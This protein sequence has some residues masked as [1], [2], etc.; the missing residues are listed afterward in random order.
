MLMDNLCSKDFTKQS[1]ARGR[2]I[3]GDLQIAAE[4]QNKIH[5]RTFE[6]SV[7]VW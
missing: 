5:M 7:S 6:R 2:C 3:G 1:Q 4:K